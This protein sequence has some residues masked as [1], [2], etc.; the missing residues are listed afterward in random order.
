M[1]PEERFAQV[2]KGHKA[3]VERIRRERP[4]F[5]FLVIIPQVNA[6]R[7]GYLQAAESYAADET[8]IEHVRA[9]FRAWEAA[10]VEANEP[11]QEAQPRSQADRFAVRREQRARGMVN[12]GLVSK[13]G[14]GYL[15]RSDSAVNARQVFER[16]SYDRRVVETVRADSG[17]VVET[18][19]M[20]STELQPP[21]ISI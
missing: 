21:L 12:R 16:R 2:R 10:M 11:A 8:S 5:N 15:V 19:D 20:R 13:G 1:T 14:A 6:A 4:G 3:G 7:E 18:R 17:A 9:R